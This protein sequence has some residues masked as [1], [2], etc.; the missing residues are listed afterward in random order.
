MNKLLIF[1]IGLSPYLGNRITQRTHLRSYLALGAM[2]CTTVWTSHLASR[3]VLQP[4][5][6]ELEASWWEDDIMSVLLRED[7]RVSSCHTSVLPV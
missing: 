2:S 7:P 5:F 4:Y 3:A 6:T 1:S